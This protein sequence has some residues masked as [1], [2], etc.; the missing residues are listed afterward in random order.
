MTCSLLGYHA[1]VQYQC[2][3]S[4][5]G[6]VPL[7]ASSTSGQLFQMM[8]PNQRFFLGLQI[9]QASIALTKIKPIWRDN[10]ISLE[11]KVKLMRS[12]STFLYACESFTLTAELKNAGDY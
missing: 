11:L 4:S 8:A 2:S 5:R 6:W 3:S 9:V 10:N 1:E 12:L 7:Y